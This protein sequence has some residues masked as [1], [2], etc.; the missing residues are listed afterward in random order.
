MK[1]DLRIFSF[2]LLCVLSAGLIA[3]CGGSDDGDSSTRGSSPEGWGVDLNGDGGTGGGSGAT[4]VDTGEFPDN[5]DVKVCAHLVETSENYGE[6]SSACEACC[7]AAGFDDSSSMYK[8][9]CTCGNMG[10]SRTDDVVC[11]SEQ[12]A[13]SCSTCCIEASYFMGWSSE[14]C[15]CLG[16]EDREVCAH[17]VHDAK[18]SEAC[19]ICCLQQGSMGMSYIMTST[20]SCSF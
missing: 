10:S 9:Q 2:Q 8:D 11:A 1:S 15:R 7:A 12:D 18:P 19:G 6:F 5:I 14:G 16:Y 17:A 3:A 20:C 4:V 13:Q